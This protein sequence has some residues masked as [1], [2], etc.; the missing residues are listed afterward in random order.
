MDECGGNCYEDEVEDDD[1]DE[2]EGE[3]MMGE[4]AIIGGEEVIGDAVT[5]GREVTINQPRPSDETASTAPSGAPPTTDSTP[6]P[7]QPASP[8]RPR[9][10]DA[11]TAQYW[12]EQGLFFGNEPGEDPPDRTWECHHTFITAKVDFI[13]TI[14]TASTAANMECSRCWSAVYPEVNLPKKISPGGVKMV[15]GLTRNGILRARGVTGRRGRT[16]ARVGRNRVP[17][18]GELAGH[19]MPGVVWR[20]D[21]GLD[22]HFTAAAAGGGSGTSSASQTQEHAI[23]DTYGD[24]IMVD[25]DPPSLTFSAP[26]PFSGAASEGPGSMDMDFNY[27]NESLSSSAPQHSHAFPLT[28]NLSNKHDYYRDHNNSQGASNPLASESPFSFAYECTSCNMLLCETCKEIIKPPTSEP[29]TPEPVAPPQEVLQPPARD[30]PAIVA[31]VRAPTPAPP[32]EPVPGTALAQGIEVAARDTE[33]QEIEM[34]RLDNAVVSPIMLEN[35]ENSGNGWSAGAATPARAAS[36]VAESPYAA[37][38]PP[39]PYQSPTNNPLDVLTPTA[40]SPLS[41]PGFRDGE[42]D[43]GPPLFP[44]TPTWDVEYLLDPVDEE[45]ARIL[46][47]ASLRDLIVEPGMG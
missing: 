21:L 15:A 6:P 19:P 38:T 37:P 41:P 5:V 28:F 13:D 11:G 47:E 18:A 45:A 9:N 12:Q 39:A 23:I 34:Q 29:E 14:K 26:L 27:N 36:T 40:L 32:P 4:A 8:R 42:T 44:L 17:T 10:L 1:D 31:A 30:I 3:V 7:Q 2:V 25:A 16:T 20:L 24:V 35:L 22:D 33:A 46:H 43:E